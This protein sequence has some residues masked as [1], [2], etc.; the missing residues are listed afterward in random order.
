[1]NAPGREKKIKQAEGKEKGNS[2][3]KMEKGESGVENGKGEN[4]VVENGK[5][6][7]GQEKR[8]R[9]QPARG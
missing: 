2:D 4:S 6:E 7:N 8:T 1:M 9:P 3:W 5:G